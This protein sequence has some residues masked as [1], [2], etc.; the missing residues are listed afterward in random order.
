MWYVDGF[1]SKEDICREF[2]ISDFDGEVVY[3]DYRYENYDG[4][5]N[6]VFINDGKVFYVYGGHCSCYGLEDQW[7]PEEITFEQVEHISNQGWG[8]W[9]DN[10]WLVNGF[11]EVKQRRL[12]LGSK[13][14]WA[15]LEKARG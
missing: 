4:S 13:T 9:K 6:V 8:F 14:F 12:K 1:A 7:S 15:V 5:A 10:A 11:R 2:R 3:A